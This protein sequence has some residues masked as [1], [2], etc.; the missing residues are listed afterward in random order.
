MTS[1]LKFNASNSLSHLGD[2]C[3]LHLNDVNIVVRLKVLLTIHNGLVACVRGVEDEK[4]IASDVYVPVVGI[5]G[6]VKWYL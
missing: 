2:D 3:T 6:C 4:S 1:C 5:L